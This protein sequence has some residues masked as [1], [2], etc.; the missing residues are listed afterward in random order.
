MLL[1]WTLLGDK[2][3][4]RTTGVHGLMLSTVPLM[5]QKGSYVSVTAQ[6]YNYY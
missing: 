4:S 1:A 3:Y 5:P 6:P 2:V